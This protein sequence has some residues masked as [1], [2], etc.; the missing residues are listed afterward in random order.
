MMSINDV[1]VDLVGA[2]AMITDATASCRVRL[3]RR[4]NP[5]EYGVL[6]GRNGCRLRQHVA[7]QRIGRIVLLQ[8]IDEI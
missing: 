5:D 8:P 6:V 3:Q 2:L 7:P 1:E 4:P